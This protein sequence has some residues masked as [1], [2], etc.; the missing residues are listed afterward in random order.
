MKR[1]LVGAGATLAL[2]LL[3]AFTVPPVQELVQGQIVKDTPGFS[4]TQALTRAAPS[5]E[6]TTKANAF[7]LQN[8]TGIR[9]VLCAE[10]GQTLTGGSLNSWVYSRMAGAWAINPDAAL[11][12]G[13]PGTR[14]RVW[15]DFKTYVGNSAWYLPAASSVTVSGGTTVTVHVSGVSAP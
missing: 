9:V 15:P 7:P 3:T 13:T 2:V 5:A 12:V 8:V 10:A 11:S 6:P 14:C 1:V 4:E